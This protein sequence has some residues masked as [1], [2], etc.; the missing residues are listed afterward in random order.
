M[1]QP[2]CQC[3]DSDRTSAAVKA[4]QLLLVLAVCVFVRWWLICSADVIARDGTV[5]VQMAR[6]WVSDPANVARR[7]NRHVGYPALMAAVRSVLI[8]LGAPDGIAG[9]ETAGRGISLAAGTLATAGIWALAGMT[10]NWRIAWMA[11]L[12][13]GTSRKWA[14]LGADVLTDATAVCFGIWAVVLSLVVLDL[15]RRGRKLALAVAAPVGIL[16]ACGYLV[17]PEVLITALLAA[18]LWIVNLARRRVRWPLAAAAVAIMLTAT[19]ACSLPY[20]LT[21]GGLTQKPGAGDWTWQQAQA[22]SNVLCAGLSLV[23]HYPVARQLLNRMF[24]AMHPVLGILALVWAG[25]T[26][27]KRLRW[28]LRPTAWPSPNDDAALLMVAGAILVIPFVIA[29][30]REAGAI[31]HR[32]LM[33]P[34]ALLV[35][36]AGAGLWGTAQWLAELA[37]RIHRS[38]DARR[39]A[40]VLCAVAFGGL[41]ARSLTPLHEGKGYYRRA[42]EFVAGH[43]REDDVVLADSSW[44]LH[45]SGCKGLLLQPGNLSSPYRLLHRISGRATIVVVSDRSIRKADPRMASYIQPPRFTELARFE[46]QPPRRERDTIRVLRVDLD[47]LRQWLRQWRRT[48]RPNSPPG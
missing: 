45:Y 13:F 33:F 23:T 28:R 32:Y 24:E 19:V 17:R 20:M 5:Y 46:R 29:R 27:I 30:A 41:L 11:A 34:A 21:I 15:L 43:A 25:G 1:I 37:R 3:P 47:E 22:P 31:S 6:E 12:L 14:A 38:I 39:I 40:I 26:V 2:T 42:A 7:Y 18:L 8:M 4:A 9:W 44:I 35:P 48:T 36:L 10:F 16:A